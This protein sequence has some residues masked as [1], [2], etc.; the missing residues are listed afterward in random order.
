MSF[1]GCAGRGSRTT[2]RLQHR[3]LAGFALGLT[4]L[5]IAACDGPN[6]TRLGGDALPLRVERPIAS[7]TPYQFDYATVNDSASGDFTRILGVDDLGEIT[8]YYGSGTKSE[9]SH[10]F[11]S[12]EPYSK[13]RVL[14]FPSAED[15]YATSLNSS[16]NRITAGYFVDSTSGHVTWGFERRQGLLSQYK[17]PK[18]PKGPNS[19][20]ELL[21]VNDPGSAVG[22]YVDSNGNDQPYELTEGLYHALNPPDFASAKA[23]GINLR[24]DIVGVEVRTDGVTEGWILRSGT[25]SEFKYPG[26][27]KTQATAVNYQQQVVGFYVDSAGTHGFILTKPG[28]PSQEFWQS[29]DE[30]NAAGTTVVTSINNHHTITGWYVD[31]SG[32]TDGFVAT[33]EGSPR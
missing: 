16:R 9:P 4:S 25:Y 15:T 28:D 29:I 13:F 6:V 2:R 22:F 19:V 24:G 32:N 26:S 3:M 20:N 27:S 21:G 30:P 10:G 33:A 5:V 8:G 23:C 12:V 17:D 31:S 7:P 18:T 1:L 11:T 14:N